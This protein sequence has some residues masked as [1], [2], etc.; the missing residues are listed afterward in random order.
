MIKNYNEMFYDSRP[1]TLDEMLSSKYDKIHDE[2]YIDALKKCVYDEIESKFKIRQCD[3]LYNIYENSTSSDYNVNIMSSELFNIIEDL[4][5]IDN[6]VAYTKPMFFNDGEKLDI[7]KDANYYSTLYE[8]L[9][10]IYNN[11]HKF[12]ELKE[13]EYWMAPHVLIIKM[14]Y[15]YTKKKVS[16]EKYWNYYQKFKDDSIDVKM[17]D[18]ENVYDPEITS[19]NFIKGTAHIISKNLDL[20]FDIP[21]KYLHGDE[22]ISEDLS[23]ENTFMNN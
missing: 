9:Y 16:L 10:N 1:V 13:T 3:I 22:T 6:F 19:F 21:F 4:G 2:L 14:E 18:E 23:L 15:P 17:Y 5:M 7:D 20:E 12:T 8:T 11:T